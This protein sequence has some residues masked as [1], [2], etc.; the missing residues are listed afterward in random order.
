MSDREEFVRAHTVARPVPFVPEITMYSAEE[1][2][3]LWEKTGPDDAPP[4]WAFPWA[5]GQGLA[6]YILDNPE[7]VRDR[8][9]LDLASGGGLVAVAAARAGARLVTANEIDPY[10]DAAIAVN[11]HANGVRIERVL[12]DL[13]ERTVTTDVVLAGDVFYSRDMTNRVLAFMR[14]SR[15]SLVLVGD[16]GRAYAPTDGAVEVA[17]Y[18]V[19]VVRD[20]EDADVKVVRVLQIG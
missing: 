16:P 4:F 11:A 1:V 17:R 3:P 15:S 10:A 5:G 18:R 13:L 7:T 14:R 8:F 6:R 19:P 2:I 12:D 9:V 20:L